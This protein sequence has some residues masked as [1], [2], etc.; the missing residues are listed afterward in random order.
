M[1]KHRDVFAAVAAKAA[2]FSAQSENNDVIITF[3]SN[4]SAPW[5]KMFETYSAY[6]LTGVAGQSNE[7]SELL[8]V[9]IRQAEVGL[10][11]RAT[12]LNKVC[13][14]GYALFFSVNNATVNF[15]EADKVLNNLNQRYNKLQQA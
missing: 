4:H 12:F 5:G 11:A 2:N 1:L 8:T 6:S 10:T 3:Y 7:Y 14:I 15:R 9:S 13:L